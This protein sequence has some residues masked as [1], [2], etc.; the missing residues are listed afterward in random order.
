MSKNI[1][2][3]LNWTNHPVLPIPTDEYIIANGWDGDKLIDY[4]TKRENAIFL[5][6][7]DPYRYGLEFPQWEMADAQISQVSEL[8]IYGGNRSSKSEHCGKRVVQAAMH[9]AKSTIWC[10][11]TTNDNSIQMQQ[12]IIYK[13]LPKELKDVKRG[14]VTN[15]SYSQKNGFSNKKLVLPNE[16][17]IIFRNYAQDLKTIEGGD[18]GSLYA[19]SGYP[20]IHNIGVWADELI[21]QTFLDTLRYRIITKNAKMYVSFTAVEG[22][23]PVVRQM[24]DDAVTLLDK[25]AELIPEMRVPI[26]QQPKREN[27]RIVYFHTADNP[28][29]GFEQ[30]KKTLEGASKEEILCRAYGLATK[31]MAGKFPK[32]SHKNNVVAHNDIPFIKDPNMEVT[33][34]QVL[35]P[36]GKKPWFMIW[37]GVIPTGEVYVWA[38]YPDISYGDWADITKGSKG[39]PGEGAKPNGYGYNDYINV[40]KQIEGDV[41]IFER[42]IDSRLGNTGRQ[43]ADMQTTMVDELIALGCDVIPAPGYEE[44]VGIQSINDLLSWDD[45]LPMTDKNKPRLYISDRCE[46]T[47]YCMLEYTGEYGHKEATKDPI[48]CV[49]YLALS[50]PVYFDLK[51]SNVSRRIGRY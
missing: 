17:E 15:I 2:E 32:F 45:K 30:I 43:S 42:I 11:Q 46:Q 51:K 29:G 24:M 3:L 7:D 18:L 13:Y 41:S 31:P 19:V 39:R 38:E 47:I 33:H 8:H 4:Y 6:K 48:D 14:K 9:N 16:S 20:H 21:P 40:M 34:Y 5:E 27:S 37:A 35:D 50:D 28:Y 10:F 36:A 49:R 25:Q 44:E 22:Y 23:S 1:R 26:L 12:K